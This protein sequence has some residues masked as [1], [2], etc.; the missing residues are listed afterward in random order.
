MKCTLYCN[1]AIGNIMCYVVIEWMIRQLQRFEASFSFVSSP[2][3]TIKFSSIAFY[4]PHTEETHLENFHWGFFFIHLWFWYTH[5]WDKWEFPHLQWYKFQP[6]SSGNK[7]TYYRRKWLTRNKSIFRN[8][9][10][11]ET[12]QIQTFIFK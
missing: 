10:W 2:S 6:Y 9:N 8:M 1:M 5:Y 12:E 11:N 3:H 7:F 4:L